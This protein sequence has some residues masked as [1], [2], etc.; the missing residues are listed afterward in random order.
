V[1]APLQDGLTASDVADRILGEL[2]GSIVA[3]A[4]PAEEGSHDGEAPEVEGTPPMSTLP[5]ILVRTSREITAVLHS[6]YRSHAF[7]DQSAVQRL[8]GTRRRLHDVAAATE[9]ATHDLLDGLDHTLVLIDELGPGVHES[10]TVEDRARLHNELRE[11]V[12]RLVTAMQ[13]QDIVAQQIAY[14]VRIL[15]DTER[16]MIGI[17]EHFDSTVFGNKGKAEGPGTEPPHDPHASM[18]NAEPRQALAD[19]IFG[20][21]AGE[22]TG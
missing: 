19:S 15:E 9:T 14:A 1:E 10:Q 18:D 2:T 11:S 12:H 4:A 6:L 3:A 5:Q 22:T 7:L 17:A 8:H 16:R 13:F 20:G 21:E